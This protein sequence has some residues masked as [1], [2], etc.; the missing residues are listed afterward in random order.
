MEQ[1]I[2][3]KKPTFWSKFS[4]TCAT[5]WK[6]IAGA[7]TY[8]STKPWRYAIYL[9]LLLIAFYIIY[10]IFNFSTTP[11]EYHSDAAGYASPSAKTAFMVCLGIYIGAIVL[12]EVLLSIFKKNNASRIAFGLVLISIGILL[13]F[14][15]C[16]YMNNPDY[17]HDYTYYGPKGHWE[18][19]YDI[20]NFNKWP[21]PELTNQ[22]YQPK[23]WHTLMA[24]IMKFHSIFIRQPVNSPVYVWYE[25]NAAAYTL[26]TNYQY[27]LLETCR[28]YINFYSALTIWGFYKCFKEMRLDGAKLVIATFLAVFVP[29]LWYMPNYG[30]NDMLALT[31]AVFALYFALRFY[32]SESWVDIIVTAFMIGLGM[33]TKLSAAMIAFPIAFLY[34]LLL[35]KY[36]KRYQASKDK[37]ALWMFIYKMAAFAVIVFPLGLGIHIFNKV[38]FGVPIGY[39]KDTEWYD[40]A[41][42]ES[43]QHIHLDFYG[44]WNRFIFFPTKDL[45]YSHYLLQWLDPDKAYFANGSWYY[46]PEWGKSDFS[47]WTAF[48]KTALF[49]E[50]SYDLKGFAAIGADFAYV[51]YILVGVLFEIAAIY[52]TVR[53]VIRLFKKASLKENALYI[54]MAIFFLTNAFSY[55]Y[56]NYKYPV[57]CSENA[58][59]AMLILIPIQVAV[60][61]FVVD[62]TKGIVKITKKEKNRP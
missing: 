32:H 54:M 13:V 35:I 62:V 59:Y 2:E 26:Y 6:K 29:S 31:F 56:F 9:P 3:E 15:N 40:G 52:Y 58:R 38:K 19:I 18:L 8:I 21:D 30:N 16:R 48:L 5:I 46:T 33:M 28:I 17:K 45:G 42:H 50:W 22:T 1:T 51:F 12:V 4:S 23:L 55:I 44:F 53:F 11:Y 24:W 7:Y 49:G 60:S 39:V 10:F 36:I 20:F 43:I 57:G 41:Y 27:S 47:V 25:P 14:T 34:L 37:K 61:S